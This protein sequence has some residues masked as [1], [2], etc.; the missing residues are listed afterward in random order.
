MP[1]IPELE[2]IIKQEE[3]AL[4]LSLILRFLEA[5]LPFCTE[6]EMEQYI[7]K[8]KS[9]SIHIIN[10]KRTWEKLLCAARVIVAIENPADVSGISSRS[11]GQRAVLKF[12]APSGAIPIVGPFTTGTFTNQIQA[13]F[14][15]PR[16]LLVTNPRADH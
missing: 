1:L 8:W 6:V 11:T 10:L 14:W 13:A 12:A 7:Y 15:E 4:S 2:R 16:L 3:T 5:G 9:D